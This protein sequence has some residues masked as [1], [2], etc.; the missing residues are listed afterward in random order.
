MDV[1]NNMVIEILPKKEWNFFDGVEGDAIPSP[2]TPLQS[3]VE[4]LEH[5]V[6]ALKRNNDL[7]VSL[8]AIA[9]EGRTIVCREDLIEEMMTKKPIFCVSENMGGDVLLSLRE[10]K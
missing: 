5:D 2:S 7:L 4:R 1:L 8:L 6:R 9:V 10:G 3:R